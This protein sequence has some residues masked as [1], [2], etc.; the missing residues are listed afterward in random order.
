MVSESKQLSTKEMYGFRETM[1]GLCRRGKFQKKII[2]L[3]IL[4]FANP[5]RSE[6]I[7]SRRDFDDIVINSNSEWLL[8]VVDTKCKD[9]LVE[10]R[11]EISDMFRGVVV[12]ATVNVSS[13]NENPFSRR[14]CPNY[15]YVVENAHSHII[16]F[17][18]TTLK[19]HT[20]TFLIMQEV[21]DPV[22][23]TPDRHLQHGILRNLSCPK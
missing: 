21:Y 15:V 4:L 22:L 12:F 5:N 16:I 23:H 17:K 9:N 8:E 3:L 11:K 7:S 19:T 6:T 18:L 2:I 14:K 20:G 1:G 10:I 13:W